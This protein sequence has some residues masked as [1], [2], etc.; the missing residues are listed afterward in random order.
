VLDTN[1]DLRPSSSKEGVSHAYSGT[2]R[3][4]QPQTSEES[5][6]HVAAGESCVIWICSRAFSRFRAF[7]ITTDR[8]KLADA[9]HVIAREY[10]FDTWPALKLHL[11]VTSEDPVEALTAAINA[12]D[13]A[14]AIRDLRTRRAH[15]QR[16]SGDYSH[17]RQ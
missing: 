5:G 17:H 11:D 4:S 6:P 15:S 10:G 16:R 8:P 14:S 9:L 3:A 12:N 7:G 2:S 1:S 13:K